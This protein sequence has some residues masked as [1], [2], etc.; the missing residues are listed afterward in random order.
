MATF[1][2]QPKTPQEHFEFLCDMTRLQL[3]YLRQRLAA[4]PEETFE[5]VLRD[6]L[7]I[8]RRTDLYDGR[9]VREINYDEPAWLGLEEGLKSL[10]V[11]HA[12][13]DGS[14]AF[15]EAG[16]ALL[17]DRLRR[18]A[19]MDCPNSACPH[20]PTWPCGSLRFD[21]PKPENPRRVGFHIGNAVGP[22][23]IFGEPAY[24]P[25][26]LFRL[27]RAARE[28]F[29][30]DSLSTCTWLNSYPPWLALFPPQWVENM[31]P[32]MLD[33]TTGMG[34]WGQ[35]V[36][37]RGTFNHKHGRMFRESRRFPFSPRASWCTFDQLAAHLAALGHRPE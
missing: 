28:Q 15:E 14:A 34:F 21:P 16:L 25:Q 37:A 11:R 6:R 2:P 4:H 17:A 33:A 23:S 20:P 12:G 24:L 1:A 8:Y 26:C 13:P 10:L 19:E 7:D 3:W 30:A 32:E 31:G 9:A 35:F 5:E 18:R 29:G 36:N 27:M 22:R